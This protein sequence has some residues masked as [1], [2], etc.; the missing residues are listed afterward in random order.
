MKNATAC[1]APP[2]DLG[3]TFMATGVYGL[4]SGAENYS[5]DIMDVY[6]ALHPAQMS[7]MSTLYRPHARLLPTSPT[8]QSLS[9]T[10]TPV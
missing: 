1:N 3:L 2:L 5:V 9:T 6:R 10:G 7:E 8:I 4:G